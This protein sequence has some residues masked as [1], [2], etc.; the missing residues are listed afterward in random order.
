MVVLFGWMLKQYEQISLHAF[1][2]GPAWMCVR[3]K[4]VRMFYII[5]FDWQNGEKEKI[6]NWNSDELVQFV[7]FEN[8]LQRPVRF[9]RIEKIVCERDERWAHNVLYCMWSW[10]SPSNHLN[11]SGYD[12]KIWG[13]TIFSVELAHN[14]NFSH[15]V[16]IAFKY[17]YTE[18]LNHATVERYALFISLS[19]LDRGIYSLK[20]YEPWP[21]K[22]NSDIYQTLRSYENHKNCYWCRGYEQL[23]TFWI[24]KL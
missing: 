12:G 5:Y 21:H 23:Y 14:L 18:Q 19:L 1:H 17:E 8:C 24:V 7:P 4:F 15:R 13:A 9:D 6:R 22:L 2:S 11:F 16:F 3:S 20:I 10:L